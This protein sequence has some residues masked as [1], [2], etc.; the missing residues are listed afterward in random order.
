MSI[1]CQINIST[2]AI[3]KRKC[4]EFTLIVVPVI[5]MPCHILLHNKML[6]SKMVMS[7]AILYQ[8]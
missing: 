1:E 8:L 5:L 3:M 2:I 6:S 7:Q 4:K